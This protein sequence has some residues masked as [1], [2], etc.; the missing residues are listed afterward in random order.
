MPSRASARILKKCH[1]DLDAVEFFHHPTNRS[2]TR[3]YCPLFV[4]NQAGEIAVTHW[5]FNGWAKYDN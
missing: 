4:K 5:R 1:A 3:D 2:W